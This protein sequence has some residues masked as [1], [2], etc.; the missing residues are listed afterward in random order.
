[1]GIITRRGFLFYRDV[2]KFLNHGGFMGK[3]NLSQDLKKHM[4]GILGIKTKGLDLSDGTVLGKPRPEYTNLDT[5]LKI[6]SVDNFGNSITLSDG[7][8]WRLNKESSLKHKYASDEIVIVRAS[9][10]AGPVIYSIE[11]QNKQ[12]DSAHWYFEG[13]KAE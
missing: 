10:L 1:M 6:Q 9:K 4:S 12:K 2:V 5:L 8:R 7:S 11:L 13:F 3:M